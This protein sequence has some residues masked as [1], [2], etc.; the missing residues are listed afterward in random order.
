MIP[1]QMHE[2]TIRPELKISGSVDAQ[3]NV[4]VRVVIPT[5]YGGFTLE[6]KYPMAQAV[7]AVYGYLR[8]KGIRFQS[9]ESGSFFSKLKGMAKK[10]AA[11]KALAPILESVKAIQKNPILARAVGLTTAVVPG[12]GSAKIAINAAADLVQKAGRGDLK[13]LANLRSLKSLAQM[14]VPQAIE[15]FGLAKRVHRVIQQ[16]APIDMLK[17]LAGPQLEQVQQAAAAAAAAFP[18]ASGAVAPVLSI[19]E[20]SAGMYAAGAWYGC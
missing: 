20:P 1:Y 8:K 18:I 6:G 4:C 9:T 19:L 14:G 12:L 5:P 10:I 17:G 16:K 7:K 13:S 15:A 3:G 2:I 11:A